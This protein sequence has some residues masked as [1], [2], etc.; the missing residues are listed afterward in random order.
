MAPD[1]ATKTELYVPN[2]NNSDTDFIGFSFNGVTSESLG[3]MRVSEGSRYTEQMLPNFQDKTAQMPGSDYTLYWESFY[4]TKSWTIQIAFDSMNENQMK[5]FRQTFNTKNLGEL[6][7]DER[8]GIH[9]LA[10][11][12]SPPQLKYICFE[13]DGNRIYKG[14]GTITM[15]SYYPFGMS[16]NITKSNIVSNNESTNKFNNDGDIPM[17][18][19]AIFQS[20]QLSNLRSIECQNKVNNSFTTYGKIFFNNGISITDTYLALNSKTNLL[21]GCSAFNTSA[22]TYTST[23]NIYNNYITSGDFFKIPVGEFKFLPQGNNTYPTCY[24]LFYRTLYL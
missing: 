21:E 6:S 8:P 20:G 10:K 2:A 15:I 4:N 18:W 17:E 19:I 1:I 12:Q 22:G 11:V 3:I 16:N 14:E 13:E 7:F 24:R 5:L 9:W 23:G